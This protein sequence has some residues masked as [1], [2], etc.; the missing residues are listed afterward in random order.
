MGPLKMIA[1]VAVVLGVLIVVAVS[2]SSAQ[3]DQVTFTKDIAPILQRSCQACHRPN[4]I[5]PMPLLTYEQVRPWAKE[6][7]ERTMLRHRRGS[8]R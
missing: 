6:I 8:M 2:S 4:S 5:A 1:A 3:T 7:K